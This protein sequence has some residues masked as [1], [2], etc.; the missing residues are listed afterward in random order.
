MALRTEAHGL[1]VKT[2]EIDRKGEIRIG[3]P[4]YALSKADLAQARTRTD[5][6]GKGARADL[7]IE[8]PLISFGNSIELGRPIADDAREDVEP[9]GRALGIGGGGEAPG[10]SQAL[11]QGN[12]ID[13]AR[14]ENRAALEVDGMQ[15]QLLEPLGN[16]APGTWEKRG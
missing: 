15:A 10:Q 9:A 4:R 11:K 13:T 5:E 2:P 6:R 14:F 1:T 16:A 8:R 12:D 3:A 7:G